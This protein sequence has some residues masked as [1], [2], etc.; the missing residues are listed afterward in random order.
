MSPLRRLP[1]HACAAALIPLL[2]SMLPALPTEAQD[3]PPPAEPA[4]GEDWQP[5]DSFDEAIS[6]EVTNVEV[7]VTDRQGRPVTG[8]TADDFVLSEDG[9]KI[10]IT[11]FASYEAEASGSW[12]EPADDGAP[13]APASSGTPSG[14]EGEI[15]PEQRLHLAILVDNWNLRPEERARVFDDLRTFIQEHLRPDDRAMVI[16]HDRGLALVQ[17]PTA[18][19]DELLAALARVERGASAG[20]SLASERRSAL[21]NIRDAYENAPPPLPNEIPDPCL[22]AWGEIQ[23]HAQGYAATTLGH[24]QGSGGALATAGDLLAGIPGRKILVYVGSGLPQQAGSEIFHYL[25]EL[26]PHKQSEI[27]SWYATYDLSWLYEEVARRANANGVTLYTVEAAVPTA[28]DDI[29]MAN[30]AGPM[31]PSATPSRGGQGIAGDATRTGGQTYRPSAAARRSA[32][33]DQEAGLFYV[34]N[35]TGGRAILNAGDF[36][37]DFARLATELRTYY[38]LGFTPEHAGDGRLHRIEVSLKKGVGDDWRVR[39][40]QSYHDKPYEQRMAEKIRGV[41]Q[42]GTDANR[43]NVRVETGEATPAGTGYRVPIRLWVPLDAV[44]LVAPRG[45]SGGARAGRLRVMMAVSDAAGNLGPVRQKLV[46]VEVGDGS[47]DTAGREH[48]VEVDLDLPTPRHVVALGLRDELGGET[49]F[50]RH[51]I[52]LGDAL[53]ADGSR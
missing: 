49:S 10:E 18:D 53:A 13:A 28:G 45:K 32:E 11:N 48:L 40:R 34:A 37:K 25:T 43:M 52:R 24:A 5:L 7:W 2:L 23:A 27:A 26:C 46:D 15:D 16:A 6:V 41:A 3:A 30:F 4:A 42:F 29:S 17:E 50:L 21:Q 12:A 22:T 35:E 36:A 9:D 31:S 44:T 20:L 47:A 1:A 51:E 8:L 14:A 38:S 33:L 19:A 39:H